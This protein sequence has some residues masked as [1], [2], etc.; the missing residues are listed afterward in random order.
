MERELRRAAKSVSMLLM[1]L[2][3]CPYLFK[4]IHDMRRF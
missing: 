2:K 1:N 4:F 3:A